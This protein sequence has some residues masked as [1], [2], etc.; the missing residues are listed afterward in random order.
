MQRVALPGL[1]GALLMCPLPSL[2]QNEAATPAEQFKLLVAAYDKIDSPGKILTDEERLKFIGQVY[3]HHEVIAENLLK[4]A[5]QH[6][7]DPIAVDAL[8]QSV[9]QVNTIPWP[10]ELIGEN[11]VRARA[12]KQILSRHASSNKL[13]PL[14]QRVSHGF[15]AEYES[16]LRAMWDTNPHES[17]KSAACV[18]LAY[19]LHARLLRIDLCRDDP[20]QAKTFAGLFGEEYL[21]GLLKQDREEVMAEVEKLYHIGQDKYADVALPEGGTVRDLVTSALYEIEQLGIGKEAPNIEGIDQ[22]GLPF[23]LH[24]YRGKVILLDFWSFV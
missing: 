16:F 6:P 22:D 20:E 7:D 17:V 24:D 8:A 18:S 9:W 4:L 1:I 5:E 10:V 2:G 19:F 13:A 15:A 21:A 12:F 23:S 14:C 11:R 3:Q